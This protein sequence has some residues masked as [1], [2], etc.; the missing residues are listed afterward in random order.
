MHNETFITT[1][2]NT[3]QQP[4]ENNKERK[5]KVQHKRTH[6]RNVN[7]TKKKLQLKKQRNKTDEKINTVDAFYMLGNK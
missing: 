7:I 4:K 1:K 5:K 3:W 2:Q 6:T